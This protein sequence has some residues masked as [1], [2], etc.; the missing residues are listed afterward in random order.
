MSAVSGKGTRPIKLL[1]KHF[2]LPVE[3][4]FAALHRLRK[5]KKAEAFSGGYGLSDSVAMCLSLTHIPLYRK[6]LNDL[7]SQNF[8]D[9]I[10]EIL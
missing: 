4:L 8:F 7:I 6:M 3:L 5:E 2:N 10:N 9:Q 1:I